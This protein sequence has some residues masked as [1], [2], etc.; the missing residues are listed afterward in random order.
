MKRKRRLD[1][2]MILKIF[3]R[4]FRFHN[5]SYIVYDRK[6]AARHFD[7]IH[8]ILRPLSLGQSFLKGWKRQFGE[9][10]KAYETV[11][12]LRIENQNFMD[13]CDPQ[14]TRILKNTDNF[15]FLLINYDDDTRQHF[16]K[17][18]LPLLIYPGPKFILWE[19]I[20]V[21]GDWTWFCV[22]IV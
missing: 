9:S 7:I 22:K 11:M 13:S 14:I 1:I 20:F 12:K 15:N 18:F 3:Q 6:T 5:L 4:T 8:N 17:N 10:G 21:S 2:L 19:L 16:M